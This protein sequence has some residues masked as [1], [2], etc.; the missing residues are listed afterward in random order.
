MKIVSFGFHCFEP[1]GHVRPKHAA[2]L[3]FC[4]DI[5]TLHT[6]FFYHPAAKGCPGIRQGNTFCFRMPI[7]T[8]RGCPSPYCANRAVCLWRQFQKHSEQPI[9][10]HSEYSTTAFP[11]GADGDFSCDS[12]S[13]ISMF[14]ACGTL[15]SL[16]TPFWRV[17]IPVAVGTF[18]SY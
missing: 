8:F 4:M 9:Y 1:G 12:H 16:N 3:P 2:L 6:H 15:F 10:H 11:R 17:V 13:I 14:P 7:I 5:R 18:I